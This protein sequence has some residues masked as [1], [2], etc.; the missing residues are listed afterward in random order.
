MTVTVAVAEEAVSYVLL[1]VI[2]IEGT[3]GT[4]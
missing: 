3:I 1:A 2:V 4:A